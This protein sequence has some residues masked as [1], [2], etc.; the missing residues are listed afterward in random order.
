MDDNGQILGGGPPDDG[1]EGDQNTVDE[2]NHVNLAAADIDP[3]DQ[4]E[5]P[6][7]TK[8]GDQSCVQRHQEA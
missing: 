8:Q 6:C 3:A 1:E 4:E 2:V 5:Y 7:E